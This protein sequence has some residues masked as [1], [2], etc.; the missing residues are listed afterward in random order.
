MGEGSTI[1][2]MYHTQIKD[3]IDQKFAEE[4]QIPEPKQP[5]RVWY[6]PHHGVFHP[7]KPDKV[8]VV[9]N[10][11]RKYKGVSLNSY[12]LPGPNLTNNSVAVLLSFRLKPIAVA[13]DISKYYHMII[14]PPEERSVQRFVY[15]P[16][17]SKELIKTWQMARHFFGG[18]HSSCVAQYA[19]RRTAQKLSGSYPEAAKILQNNSYVDNDNKGSDRVGKR[20]Q[21][22]E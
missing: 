13:C 17:G 1:R 11:S 10:G 8:R 12:L 19:L 6:L 14:V 22:S 3:Y 2:K 21:N 4:V 16:P 15:R 7:H 20:Y 18:K 9:F 5:E